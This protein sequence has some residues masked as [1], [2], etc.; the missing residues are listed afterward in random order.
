M[1]GIV[2]NMITNHDESFPSAAPSI[3]Q[4]M[5]PTMSLTFSPS[6][7]SAVISAKHS[8][9]EDHFHSFI[10]PGIALFAL[11]CMIV[12][13]RFDF[14]KIVARKKRCLNICDYKDIF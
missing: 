6:L 4:S 8:E 2:E 14:S 7:A 1:Y 3:Y 9:N 11:V 10:A 5:N 12:M 13:C